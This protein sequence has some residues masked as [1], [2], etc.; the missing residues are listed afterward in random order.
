MDVRTDGSNCDAQVCVVSRVK[1]F[2]GTS[3]FNATSGRLF[4]F[5]AVQI[6]NGCWNR[7][8]AFYHQAGRHNTACNQSSH[9]KLVLGIFDSCEAQH[10]RVASASFFWILAPA[11]KHRRCMLGPRCCV[12]VEL[13]AKSTVTLPFEIIRHGRSMQQCI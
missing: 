3:T 7:V 6:G 2:K 9:D 5:A 13:T 11:Q 4:K 10:R 1:V 8:R 12:E